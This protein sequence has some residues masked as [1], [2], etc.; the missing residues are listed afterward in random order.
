MRRAE[1]FLPGIESGSR[2]DLADAVNADQDDHEDYETHFDDFGDSFGFVD[3]GSEDRSYDP[4]AFDIGP[5]FDVSDYESVG[6]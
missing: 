5:V 1:R 3:W 2:I 4:L 6:F